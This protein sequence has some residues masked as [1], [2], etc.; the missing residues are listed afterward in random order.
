M[1]GTSIPV[2]GMLEVRGTLQVQLDGSVGLQILPTPLMQPA[3]TPTTGPSSGTAAQYPPHKAYNSAVQYP[4]HSAYSHP[5]AAARAAPQSEAP[6]YSPPGVFG[7]TAPQPPTHS[8]LSVTASAATASGE[9]IA[10]V[11]VHPTPE[12]SQSPATNFRRDTA[13]NAV[14]DMRQLLGVE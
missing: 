13:G 4:P 10:G 9:A 7:T 8:L 1:A 3:Y 2:S 5:S 12:R 6:P 14:Y 11:G